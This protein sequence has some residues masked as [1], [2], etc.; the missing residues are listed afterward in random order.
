M[1][2]VRV[3]RTIYDVV[4]TTTILR[5]LALLYALVLLIYTLLASSLIYDVD[6]LY[7]IYVL[8]MYVDVCRR[9]LLII[10]SSMLLDLASS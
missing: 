6:M 4:A 10:S 3:V 7:A 9:I 8:Y 1:V 2:I 5:T